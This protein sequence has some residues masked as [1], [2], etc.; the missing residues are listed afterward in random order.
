MAITSVVASSVAT[1]DAPSILATPFSGVADIQVVVDTARNPTSLATIPSD[2]TT[3]APRP[4][5][6]VLAVLSGVD[7]C[8]LISNIDRKPTSELTRTG[9]PTLIAV[10]AG[11]PRIA[12]EGCLFSVSSGRLRSTAPAGGRP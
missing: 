1:V 9:S 12:T 8:A 4:T 7:G 10:V 2:G 11:P 6:L 5:A 3:L